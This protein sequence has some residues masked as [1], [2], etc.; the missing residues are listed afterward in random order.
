MTARRLI[1]VCAHRVTA[2]HWRA[3]ELIE[4]GSFDATAAGQLQFAGY[5]A[6]NPKSIFLLLANVAEEGF[7]IETIPFLRGSDRHAIVARKLGQAFFN[8]LL[9]TSRCV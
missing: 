6:E 2:F 4:E 5:L 7:Q 3:G 1:Y 8:C 9:Y